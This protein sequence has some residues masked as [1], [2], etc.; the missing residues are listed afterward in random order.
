MGI[1]V[2]LVAPFLKTPFTIDDPLYLREAQ[3][4][5]VDPLHPQAFN[6]VWSSDRSLR[7]SDILPGGILVP[8]LL[9]PVALTVCRE[10]A[11]HLVTLLLLLVAVL[12]TVLLAVRLG[13]DSKQA[14]LAA[15]LT[16]ASPAVLGMAGTVMPDVAAM[17]LVI[18]GMERIL[19]WRTDRKWSQAL[20]AALWLTLAALTRVH[21]ILAHAPAAVFLMDGVRAEKASAPVR[22]FPSRFLPIVS[23]PIAFFAGSLLI[24]DP[25]SMG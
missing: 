18:L 5:L 17:T 24:S 8:Y 1:A 11:G 20:L 3:H 23:T 6:I 4:V 9:L 19:A 12:A 2:F 10:W 21:T 7:A 25:A 13:L 22:R 15:I 16:A 14:R